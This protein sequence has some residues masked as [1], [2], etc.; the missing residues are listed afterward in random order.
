MDTLCLRTVHQGGDRV[1]NSSTISVQ[2]T[3]SYWSNLIPWDIKPGNFDCI[4]SREL[5]E[6]QL[7]QQQ[8]QH[9]LV[10]LRNSLLVASDTSGWAEQ[11][12]VHTKVPKKS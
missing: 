2:S 10:A 12:S 3:L 4:T 11:A 5:L 8:W 7:L 9:K 6:S 1:S